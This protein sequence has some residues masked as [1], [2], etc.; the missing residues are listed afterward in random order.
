M[1]G[2]VFNG[3]NNGYFVDIGGA[4]STSMSNTFLLE[5]RYHWRGICLEANPFLF[6]NLRSMRSTT[7]LNA[8]LDSK[9]GEV[10]FAQKDVIGGI[11]DNNTDNRPE[12]IGSQKANVIRMQAKTLVSILIAENAPHTIDYLSIDV[13]G[14]EDRILRG[15][16]FNKYR[17]N[18]LTIERPEADLREVLSRNGYILIKDL[19]SMDAF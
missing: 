1:F 11:V 12:K 13:E 3:K 6:E 8:C 7:C 15:F 16:P 5:K 10:V 2:E 14:P 9:E 18:C 4:D 17:F 19:P